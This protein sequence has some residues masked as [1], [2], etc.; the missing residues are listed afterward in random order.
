MS[1][2]SQKVS[3]NYDVNI[4]NTIITNNYFIQAP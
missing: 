1:S 4:R 3:D 2:T